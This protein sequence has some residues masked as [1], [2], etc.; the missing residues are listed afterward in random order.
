VW[1]VTLWLVLSLTLFGSRAMAVEE[2]HYTTILHQ[3]AF[4]IRDY[5]SLVAA[6]VTVD[7]SQAGAASKGFRLLARY[8]FGGN[9]GQRSIPMTAP[10]AQTPAS[11]P[12][13]GAETG[14]TWIVRFFMPTGS[15]LDNLPAPNDP[16]VHLVTLP[17]G[18]LAVLRFSGWVFGHTFADKKTALLALL[19][20]H[21]LHPT[22]PVTLAQYNPPWTLW[23]MRRNEVM[24]PI[25]P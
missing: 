17:A 21:S 7:G 13:T 9:T 22:G 4:E 1:R 6:E 12:A 24:V 14:N 2:P 23:F 25:A 5:P 18:R 10:V 19:R 3:G 8:I 15:T 11:A 16:A 20:R